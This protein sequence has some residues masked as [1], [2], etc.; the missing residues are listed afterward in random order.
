M[1]QRLT[2]SSTSGY[3]QEIDCLQSRQRPRREGQL[4]SGMLS[5][6]RMD[7]PHCGQRERGWIIDSPFGMREIQT[8][9]KLPKIRPDKKPTNWI[10]FEVYGRSG[11]VRGSIPTGTFCAK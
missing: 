4:R 7:A 5:Y 3:C 6:Q 2:A 1:N 9:R 10:T 8:F 11:S